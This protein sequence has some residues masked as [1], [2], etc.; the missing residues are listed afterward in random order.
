VAAAALLA[1]QTR[2]SILRLL[3]DGPTCV[4]ELALAV[5][6]RDNHVSNHLARLRDAGLVRASRHEANARFSYHER[7]QVAVVT[8]RTA[9]ADV[10][11]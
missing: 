4:S 7:D 2:A 9:L 10:L 6:E 8:A 11:R 3:A 1:D 5:G